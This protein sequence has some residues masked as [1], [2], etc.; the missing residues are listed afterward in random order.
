MNGVEAEQIDEEHDEG[1]VPFPMLLVEANIPFTSKR[2]MSTF[3]VC[4]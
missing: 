1:H 3:S 4:G 2:Y